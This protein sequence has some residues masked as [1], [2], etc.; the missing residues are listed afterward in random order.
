M[1]AS[2]DDPYMAARTSL[3]ETFK[4]YTAALAGLGAI[5]AGG[6]SF[7]ILPDLSGDE[8]MQAIVVGTIVFL[9]ILVSIVITQSMLFVEPFPRDQINQDQ[10]LADEVRALQRDLLPSDIAD[11]AQITSK[12]NVAIAAKDKS[13]IIRLRTVDEKIGSFAAYLDLR[14]KLKRAGWQLLFLFVIATVGI[15]YLAFLQGRAKR[16][17]T[18][19]VPVTFAPGAEWSRLAASLSA[20]CGNGA[21]PRGT[22][23]FSATGEADAPFPGWWSIQ[24][25]GPGPCAGVEIAAPGEGLVVPRVP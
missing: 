1:M 14:R 2:P 20:L 13:E 16:E 6:V 8:L 7:A 9:V 12:L 4:W 11:F 23:P 25:Q 24:I 22:A 19:A 18:A 17:D 10:R 3:R 15:S 5:V 21:G